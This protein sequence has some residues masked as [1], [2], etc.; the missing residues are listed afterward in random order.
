MFLNHIWQFAAPWDEN[1]VHDKHLDKVRATFVIGGEDISRLKKLAN[2]SAFVVASAFV[3]TNLTKSLAEDDDDKIDSYV[4]PADSRGRIEP[5]V[6]AT[7]FG[8]CLVGV[9]VSMRRRDLVGDGGF[10]AAAAEIATKIEEMEREGALKNSEN[11]FTK[12]ETNLKRGRMI[13]VAGSPKLRVYETDFGWGRPRKSEPVHV[14][15]S[16]SVYF[17]D[18]RDVERGGIEFGLALGRSDMDSFVGLFESGLNQ[19]WA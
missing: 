4:F 2:A 9:L 13:S 7:Y 15:S 11:W 10:A 8:N 5:K 3:W 6:P 19:L 17:S 18:V 16:G 14:D 1:S 12:Y